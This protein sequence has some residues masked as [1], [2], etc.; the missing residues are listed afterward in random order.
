MVPETFAFLI[1]PLLGIIQSH[2]YHWH[3]AFLF[4]FFFFTLKDL[5]LK[6]VWKQVSDHLKK[7]ESTRSNT[8]KKLQRIQSIKKN[9]ET[10]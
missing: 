1:L 5:I 7:L 4:F 10:K 2:L 8:T 9:A 3:S 6:K